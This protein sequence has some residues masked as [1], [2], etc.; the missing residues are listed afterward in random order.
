MVRLIGITVKTHDTIED[1]NKEVGVRRH[2][3]TS[4]QERHR[5]PQLKPLGL[6][7]L[8]GLLGLLVLLQLL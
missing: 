3:L 5:G 1:L 4:F 7:G 8:Q 2:N 6:L